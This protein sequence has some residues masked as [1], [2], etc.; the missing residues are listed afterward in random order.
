M[1]VSK[2]QTQEAMK[3][4]AA[5]KKGAVSDETLRDI[6]LVMVYLYGRKDEAVAALFGHSNER[7]QTEW[8]NRS[9]TSFWCHL[10]MNNRKNLVRLSRKMGEWKVS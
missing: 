1:T 8:R 2:E 9:A 7:Y 6:D 3:K 5:A 4:L 10:D